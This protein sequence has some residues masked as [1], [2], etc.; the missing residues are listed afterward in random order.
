M[1]KSSLLLTHFLL[2]VLKI[3]KDNRNWWICE[4][5]YSSIIFGF[6]YFSAI[7][8]HPYKFRIVIFFDELHFSF[9]VLQ[10]LSLIMGLPL[11]LSSKVSTCIAG[12]ARDKGLIPGSERSSGGGQ[13][14][15]VQHSCLENPMD[16]GAWRATV[17]RVAVSDTTEATKHSTAHSQ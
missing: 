17:H 1:F 11:W 4:F 9:T 16:W 13:G 15:P 6:M 8:L 5:L 2:L 7:L 12:D 3:T 10:D 14:T